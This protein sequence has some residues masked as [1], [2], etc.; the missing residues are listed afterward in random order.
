VK[1]L[2]ANA[3][4]C[5][6][7]FIVGDAA[8]KYTPLLLHELGIPGDCG[9]PSWTMDELAPGRDFSVVVVGAG[10]SGLVMAHRLAQAKIPFVVVEK[11]AEV[12]GTWWENS[13]PGCRLDTSNFAYSYSFAQKDDWP[14]QYSPQ[15]AI[16][17][18][19]R[20]VTDL[21]SLRQHIQFGVEAKEAA[22]NA[23]TKRWKLSVQTST[24]QVKSI[25]ANVVILAVGQ[26]NRP[27]L[28][29]IPGRDS[30]RGTSFHSSNWNHDV[31][32]RGRKV[33]V[34]GTGA[35]AFQIIPAIAEQVSELT[36]YQRTPAW[37][38]PAPNYHKPLASGLTWLFRHIPY[39]H[40]WFRFYQFWVSA[41]NRLPF[42]TVDPAWKADD[43]VSAANEQ[44]RKALFDHL[45]P[46]YEDRPDLLPKVIPRYPPGAKRMLRDNG[47]WAATLKRANVELV[48]APIAEIT[49]T[50]V[51]TNDEIE[52][53][54]DVLIYAT[55]FLASDFYGPIRILGVDGQDLQRV[56]DGDARAYLG[57][58]VP[59][60]PNLFSLFGPNTAL[61][62]N[63]SIFFMSE[64]AS[65]YVIE[66]LRL[67]LKGDCEAMECRPEAYE[68]F[69]AEVDAGN[70]QMA[71]GGIST[72]NSW[73]RNKYGRAS[74]AW[75]FPLA[76]Y[77]S[78][79][80]RPDLSAFLLTSRTN[81]RQITELC[82]TT[83]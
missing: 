46:Q 59:G 26:L 48:T 75:P 38:L 54:A 65:N 62:I 60:F 64:C 30:F 8:L 77:W 4:R 82:A 39:Y 32:L 76:E 11:N 34:I 27:K 80:R 50:G 16:L 36:V 13:Y 42:F 24:G 72:V 69:A 20:D 55:G 68:S 41:E 56:W 61:V 70:A 81:Q 3:L 15:G 22:Y 19:F 31:D 18:Y 51:R 35:S 47:V 14:Y 74:Q 43:S 17:E 29:D 25:E 73:Y 57:G 83:D 53:A 44:L 12:G 58:C 78:R 23:D 66:C 1:D 71:W 2:S 7:E 21:L 67:M 6:L 79:T 40:R 37:M 10:M 49:P 5:L 63:G 52:R 33:G 28:P 9:A 45:A